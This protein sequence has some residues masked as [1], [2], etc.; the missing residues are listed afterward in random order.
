MDMDYLV[1]VHMCAHTC[2][3]VNVLNHVH[4]YMCV[5]ECCGPF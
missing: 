3:C 5:S 1:Y 2:A 4:T